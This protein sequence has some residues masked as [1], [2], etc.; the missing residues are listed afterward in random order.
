MFGF[1][2]IFG[3]NE[4]KIIVGVMLDLNLVVVDKNLFVNEEFFFYYIEFVEVLGFCIYFK[5]LYYVIF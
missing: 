5:L 4:I 1:C 2:V 3:W